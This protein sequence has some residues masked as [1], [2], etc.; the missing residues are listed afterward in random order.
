[1]MNSKPTSRTAIQAMFISFDNRK[2]D[3]APLWSFEEV[4]SCIGLF[5]FIAFTD[6]V[7]RITGIIATYFDIF[8]RGIHTHKCIITILGIFYNIN[9]EGT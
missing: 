2:V 4:T 1:M 7:T 6:W 3:S 9:C 8:I 5:A